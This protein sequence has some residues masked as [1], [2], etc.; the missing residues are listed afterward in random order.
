MLVNVTIVP[1]AIMKENFPT[2]S[3]ICEGEKPETSARFLYN[4][5]YNL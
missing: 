5:F 3:Y 1:A 2:K 4:I